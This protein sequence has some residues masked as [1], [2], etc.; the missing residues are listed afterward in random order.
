LT[1]VD[2]GLVVLAIRVPRQP[3]GNLPVLVAGMPGIKGHRFEG[4]Y[5]GIFR[6]LGDESTPIGPAA[7]HTA[8]R[9]GIL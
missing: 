7:I 1:E 6:R 8:L 4:A 3:S 5:W 2:I 9:G